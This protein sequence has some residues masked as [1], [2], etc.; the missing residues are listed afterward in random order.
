MPYLFAKAVEATQ[1]GVPVMRAMVLEHPHDPACAPLD[2]QY[3]LGE[4]LLVAPVFTES[5]EVDV[6]LP[7]APAGGRW[8]HLLSGETRAGGRWYREQHGMLSLPLY[9]APGTVLPW[10]GSDERPDYDF[11]TGVSLR[12]FELADGAVAP[13][14]VPTLDGGVAA[15]GTVRRQGAEYHAAVEQGALSDWRLDV[16]GQRSPVLAQGSALT[17]TATT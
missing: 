5:G 6:Y 12:V 17:W 15:R 14:E 3:Q 9:V 10:G 7:D 11:S 13:F 1:T 4:A 8:T 16:A 2:R